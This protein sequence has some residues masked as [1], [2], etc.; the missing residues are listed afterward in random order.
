LSLEILP[1]ILQVVVKEVFLYFL[2][3]LKFLTRLHELRRRENFG[4]T[5]QQQT[6]R[7]NLELTL[8]RMQEGP[9]SVRYSSVIFCI[10][11]PL[12]ESLAAFA[13]HRK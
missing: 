5:L 11:V 7:R 6:S 4:I 9:P 8:E 12:S 3:E 10:A 1:K 2:K 13:C